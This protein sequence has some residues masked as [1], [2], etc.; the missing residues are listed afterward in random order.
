MRALAAAVLLMSALVLLACGCHGKRGPVRPPHRTSDQQ[1]GPEEVQS[2]RMFVRWQERPA[3]GSLRPL[4][5]VRAESGV[6]DARTQSGTLRV[7]TGM[8]YRAGKLA[9]TFEAPRVDA[10][11]DSGKVIAS[12]AVVVR[13]VDPAG[14]TVRAARVTWVADL[15]RIVA[16]GDVVFEDRPP[17]TSRPVA[18]G[19]KFARVTADTELR[20]ITIP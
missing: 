18:W 16:E 9:A 3:S 14:V 1:E 11:R 19:G 7:A 4:L 17:G 6:V 13:S 5:E 8:L 10:T 15:S 2:R 12:G 20:K